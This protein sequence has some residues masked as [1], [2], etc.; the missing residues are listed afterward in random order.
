MKLNIVRPL[1]LVGLML[2]AS[3]P[4]VAT[5]FPYNV[6]I[7]T[8]NV[9]G[10][11]GAVYMQFNPG[12]ILPVDPASVSITDFTIDGLP[13][14]VGPEGP[15]F[16]GDVTGSLDSL[17]L[18]I[19][20]TEGL[21]D[22]LHFVTF[23]NAMRFSV[24][25]DLPALTG[26]SGSTFYFELDGDDGITPILADDGAP[27]SGQI[28]YD[29]NG[30]FTVNAFSEAIGIEAVPEPASLSLIGLGL[31][32]GLACLARRPARGP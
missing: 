9:N 5:L 18:T 26:D 28:D 16:T 23:G 15:Y 10:T 31:A 32:V 1:L 4:G 7:D 22:Y 29:V 12:P 3:A 13:V 30:A 19:A 24:D 25:F 17:P 8:S 14:P 11:D 20:N 27:L 2:L 21:N 6:I